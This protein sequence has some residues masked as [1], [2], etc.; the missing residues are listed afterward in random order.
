M[1]SDIFN[2]IFEAYD[3]W[4]SGS[5]KDQHPPVLP[6]HGFPGPVLAFPSAQRPSRLCGYTSRGAKAG[7]QL[8]RE[9][10]LPLEKNPW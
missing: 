3:L 1:I 7:G 5:L 8:L 2:I 4:F 6:E 9:V 10:Y